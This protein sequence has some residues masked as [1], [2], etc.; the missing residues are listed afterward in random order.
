LNNLERQARSLIREYGLFKPGERVLVCVSGGPDSVALL[1]LLTFTLTDYK[2]HIKVVHFN[3]NLRGKASDTDERFVR[4]LARECH[5]PIT[6]R[7]FDVKGYSKKK[8]LS[9]EMAARSLRHHALCQIARRLRYSKAVTGHTLSDQA[10]TIIMRLVRGTG[11]TGLCGI[12]PL[13]KIDGITYV[14]PLLRT[15]RADVIDY[16]KRFELDWRT[17]ATNSQNIYTRNRVRNQVMPHLKKLNPQIES[18]LGRIAEVAAI[19]DAALDK[20]AEKVLTSTVVSKRANEIFLDFN[21]FKRYNRCLQRRAI[22]KILGSEGSEVSCHDIDQVLNLLDAASGAKATPRGW[23]V[24]YEQNLIHFIRRCTNQKQKEQ[25]GKKSTR[26]HLCCPGEVQ[27]N[28]YGFQIR[29]RLS[30]KVPENLGDGRRVTYFD[31]DKI[32]LDKLWVRTRMEGDRF[33]PFGLSH[34]TGLKKIMI[35]LRIPASQRNS[36]PIVGAANDILWVAGWR[37][38]AIAQI[39]KETKK[40]LELTYEPEKKWLNKTK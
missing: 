28:D 9:I 36:I 40:V 24:S 13:K 2:L 11:V 37:R 7:Q 15:R 21:L 33:H 23:L 16:L 30:K 18:S 27:T 31:A 20:M 3:H 6:V 26:R 29:A 32:P 5:I 35:N 8:K 22:R 17:D 10:E 39:S 25:A 34:T 12:Q 1:H 14:R 38:S 4:K 19:E